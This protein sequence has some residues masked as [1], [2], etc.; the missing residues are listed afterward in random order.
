VDLIICFRFPSFFRRIVLK[1]FRWN[2]DWDLW[3]E[4]IAWIGMEWHRIARVA[5]ITWER[6]SRSQGLDWIGLDW[7]GLDSMAEG[8]LDKSLEV[9]VRCTA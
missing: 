5:S 3:K 2:G 9:I 1:G 4:R 7:I 8:M 6:R